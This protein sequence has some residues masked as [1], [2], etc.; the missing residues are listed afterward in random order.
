MR[1]SPKIPFLIL[2]IVNSFISFAFSSDTLKYT[3]NWLPPAPSWIPSDSGKGRFLLNFEDARYNINGIPS[4][5][6]TLPVDDNCSEVELQ[7][8]SITYDTVIY[9]GNISN[10]NDYPEEFTFSANI[11][12][13]EKKN[14]VQISVIPVIRKK[15]KLILIKGFS[16][17]L[18]QVKHFSTKK[19]YAERW[20]SS[21]VLSSGTWKKITVPQTGIYRITFAEIKSL[22][23][24]NPA[25]IRIFGN[26]G[27][28]LPERFNGTTNDDLNEIPLFLYK[29]ADGIFNDG[30]YILFYA[31]GPVHWEYNPLNKRFVHTK[32]PFTDKIFY[33]ITSGSNGARIAD[34]TPVEQPE[35]LNINSFVDYSVHEENLYNL[36][37]SGRNWYGEKFEMQASKTFSFAFPDPVENSNFTLEAE[38]LARSGNNTSFAVRYNNQTIATQTMGRVYI[39]DE[40]SNYADIRTLVAKGAIASK[41]VN[42]V[43]GFDN[44]G[45]NSAQGWLSYMRINAKRKLKYNNTQLFFRD[46]TALFQSRTALYTID[47]ASSDLLLWDV[48]NI[49]KVKSIKYNL[50]GQQISF[51]SQTDTLRDFVL[52]SPSKALTPDFLKEEE[53][54][55][56]NQNLHSLSNI[57]MVII[58]H[59][60]FLAEAEELADIHR[61]NDHLTVVTVTPNQVYN[62]FSSGNPDPAA[63]RNFMK[64]LY[65][66][67]VNPDE[68]PK[69]LLL[70][71]DGSYKNFNTADSKESNTD[72]ILTYQSANSLRPVS[73]Y[74]SDDYFG[75]L[76]DSET[77]EMG[78]LDIGT[79]RFPVTTTQQAKAVLN[80]IKKYISTNAAGNWRNDICFIADDEDGNIHM[81]QADQISTYLNTNF[82][83]FNIKKIYSD[84]Y[85]QV[86]TSAGP[87]YPDVNKAIENT[88]KQGVLIMNYTGHGG[89]D[90]L[91]HEQIL[92]QAEVKSWNNSIYPLFVTAT[93][94]FSR[95]DDYKR[96]TAG[97]DV[98]LNENGGGI[99]LLTT[100]RLVYSGPNFILNQEF[101]R[102]F[103]E[104]DNQGNSLRLGD[105]LKRTKNSSGNDINKL[106][107]TLLG[108]PALQL[109]SPKMNIKTTHINSKDINAGSDTLKAYKE[110][111]VNGLVTDPAGNISSEFNGIIYPSLF[112]K[113]QS[114][115]TL[116]N[117]N[118]SPFTYEQQESL[119]YKGKATVKN[120]AF[121]FSFVV[122]RE[123]AYNYGNGRLSYYAADNNIMDATGY[124]NNFI[125]GGISSETNMDKDGPEINL[126]LN[127]KTFKNGGIANQFPTLLA[128]LNDEHG[129]NI[130][131]SGIGHNIIGILDNNTSNA[132]VLNNY[133]ESEI[134]NYKKGSITYNLPK[135]NP[136]KHT[137]SL[138]AWD[139]FNN[140]TIAEIAFVVTDSARLEIKNL[141]NYPNPFSGT[142]TFSFEHNQPGKTLQGELQIYSITGNL[143]NSEKVTIHS[144]GFTSGPILWDGSNSFYKKPE[145]GI[146]IY[147]FIFRYNGDELISESKKMI[148]SE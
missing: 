109:A 67:A 118:G 46:T 70:F 84:S 25:D 121:E 72:F 86:T 23:F 102:N 1:F 57:Q 49:N 59:P 15:D 142:T 87:R 106:C 83:F 136:G 3:L 93:C 137:L 81:S 147:R 110:I 29:G 7:S 60:S 113:K 22:G 116:N 41:D 95:F 64:M 39:N 94:E 50:S 123:I 99:A 126:F 114:V 140:S 48:S 122:P 98:L 92:R 4:F 66:K 26:G 63:Y 45:D 14:L 131:G 27:H 91:A 129:I 9:S 36:I 77:I 35:E 144:D 38:I 51:K 125:I 53:N 34:A 54:T 108:D 100:T 104:K 117:D 111:T 96:T 47:N 141:R 10:Q 79:G 112:D 58:A 75:L 6:S 28:L 43:M 31:T 62:E 68:T 44:Q 101:Y 73:S 8:L 135:L 65:D 143:I 130:S 127:D 5:I 21:S 85:P 139:I 17:K 12:Q 11:L 55:V 146:Y 20:K 148:V 40:T 33:F 103:A 56:A 78:L 2:L 88:L 69:Y 120:G 37:R 19:S 82:P 16:F 145:K 115:K 76:D 42:I 90:G 134:D 18:S 138:K 24:A 80:K 97:E 133:F 119:L 13:A 71:G 52:F 132:I 30:D 32:H 61:N 124:F 74:V 128:D 107:F 105:I 89:E